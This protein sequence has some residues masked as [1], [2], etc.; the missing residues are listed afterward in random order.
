MQCGSV[1]TLES[2]LLCSVAAW[3]RWSLDFC[4]VWQRGNAGLSGSAVHITWV[5]KAKQSLRRAAIVLLRA[6]FDGFSAGTSVHGEGTIHHVTAEISWEGC[7]F[8]LSTVI[9]F[10]SDI[11]EGRDCTDFPALHHFLSCA[12]RLSLERTHRV[13]RKST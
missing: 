7:V 13:M 8:G 9:H 10:S 12:V 6:V 2:R 1:E 3:R 5:F 11:H 4:A